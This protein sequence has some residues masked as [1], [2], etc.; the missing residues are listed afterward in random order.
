M[1]GHAGA[2][3]RET[4]RKQE[5]MVAVAVVRGPPVYYK[6]SVPHNRKLEEES[7]REREKGKRKAGEIRKRSR[8]KRRG[9]RGRGEESEKRPNYAGREA[10]RRGDS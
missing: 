9:R 6:G 3:R 10:E 1:N 8:V 2:R 5:E 7:E 4:K